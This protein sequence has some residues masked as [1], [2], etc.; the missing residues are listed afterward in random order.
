MKQGI[1][2][3]VAPRGTCFFVIIALASGMF[4]LGCFSPLI[5]VYVRDILHA[6]GVHLR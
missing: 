3:I 1:N 2:F 5:A 4:V 6:P